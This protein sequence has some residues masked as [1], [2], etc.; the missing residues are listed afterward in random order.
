MTDEQEKAC[1]IV[2]YTA[3][4]IFKSKIA[5]KHHQI[6]IHRTLTGYEIHVGAGTV[7]TIDE[8]NNL[9]GLWYLQHTPLEIRID[10]SSRP[11]NNNLRATG[12]WDSHCRAMTILK[13]E[14]H[15]KQNIPFVPFFK[16]P[17]TKKEKKLSDMQG[18]VDKQI[19]D[20]KKRDTPFW[21]R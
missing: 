12:N 14:Y 20:K 2:K 6:I 16:K 8:D 19:E 1:D 4:R 11:I 15:G 18:Q 21:K 5:G 7:F 9:I 17:A 10:D 3:T 13:E